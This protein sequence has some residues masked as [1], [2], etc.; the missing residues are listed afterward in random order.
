MDVQEEDEEAAAAAAAG[1]GAG[2]AGPGPSLGL[3]MQ[4]RL[5]Q[6]RQIFNP[7]E[8]FSMLSRE[9]KDIMRQN[10]PMLE[11]D[12]VDNDVY[13]WDIHLYRFEGGRFAEVRSIFQTGL[14]FLLYG[15]LP[16]AQNA[17]VTCRRIDSLATLGLAVQSLILICCRLCWQA[18]CQLACRQS[19]YVKCCSTCNLTIFGQWQQFEIRKFQHGLVALRAFAVSPRC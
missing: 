3:S 11:V 9:L 8:A 5:A 18:T 13:F 10:D 16:I 6:Q 7:R 1:A 12:T 4:E 14:A 19:E 15:T 2:A 17:P